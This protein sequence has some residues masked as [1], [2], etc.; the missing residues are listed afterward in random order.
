MKLESALKKIRNR[1]K[2]VKREVEI[3]QCDYHNNN[4]PKVYVHF[5]GS[6]QLISFWT[7]S[8]GWLE[9]SK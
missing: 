4:H 5:E 2:A 3:E 7:N 1:A 9:P 6:N 8:D